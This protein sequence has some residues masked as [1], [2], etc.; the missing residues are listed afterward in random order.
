MGDKGLEMSGEY[1]KVVN[2]T[3]KTTLCTNC[4]VANN[5]ISRFI[6]LMGKKN[7]PEGNGL[8]ITPCNSIHMFFMNMPLDIIF[9]DKNNMIVHLLE[10]IKP[11]SLSG[12]MHGSCSAIEL[13]SGTIKK[14]SSSV[15]D[16]LQFINI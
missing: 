4:K 16:R 7:L 9:I 15:G 3:K 11:W 12:I 10:N 13:P 2:T 14:T 8:L 5:F 1:M 6:G